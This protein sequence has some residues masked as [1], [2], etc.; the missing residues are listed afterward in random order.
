MN[1]RLSQDHINHKIKKMN[2]IPIQDF[3]TPP[4]SDVP[5]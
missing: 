3:E 5:T 4:S 1:K 2:K